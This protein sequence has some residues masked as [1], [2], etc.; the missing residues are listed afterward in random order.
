MKLKHELSLAFDLFLVY[1]K[2]HV[3]HIHVTIIMTL[4][5]SIHCPVAAKDSIEFHPQSTLLNY[6]KKAT[7]V[8]SAAAPGILSIESEQEDKT[9]FP[10]D[11]S[12]SLRTGVAANVRELRKP[13]SDKNLPLLL[14]MKYMRS[15]STNKHQEYGFDVITGAKHLFYINGVYKFIVDATYDVRPYYKLGLAM[16]FDEKDPRY[17]MVAGIGVETL[18][19]LPHSLRGDLD[20]YLGPRDFL[21]LLCVGWSRA[22]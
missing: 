6:E 7:K 10:Y 21:I 20:L 8:G 15:S 18:V 13:E 4:V 5:L 12:L 3:F 16:R 9:V 2:K 17:S 22:F 11:S 19:E 1:F 14:G